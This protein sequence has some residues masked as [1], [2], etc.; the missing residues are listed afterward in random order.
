[1]TK[2]RAEEREKK[3][4]KEQNYTRARTCLSQLDTQSLLFN[5]ISYLSTMTLLY[6][7]YNLTFPSRIRT[8]TSQ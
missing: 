7:A 6:R 4:K 3:G 2:Q 1:M 5:S 8:P